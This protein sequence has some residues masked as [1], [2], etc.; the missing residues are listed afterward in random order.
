MQ[1][2][3]INSL[4]SCEGYLIFGNQSG[5]KKLKSRFDLDDSNL[6]PAVPPAKLCYKPPYKVA[7]LSVTKVGLVVAM[8]LK[9]GRIL[10]E[11]S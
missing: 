7:P 6:N 9:R 8:S 10:F 1:T 11:D 4:Y 5:P 2:A 3:K